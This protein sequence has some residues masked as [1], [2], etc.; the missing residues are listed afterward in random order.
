MIKQIMHFKWCTSFTVYS[1]LSTGTHHVVSNLYPLERKPLLRWYANILDNRA[2]RSVLTFL[3]I[4]GPT[5]LLTQVGNVPNQASH[6]PFDLWL[7]GWQYLS[8]R[9]W[10]CPF[11]L[12][13]NEANRERSRNTGKPNNISFLLVFPNTIRYL[14]VL[15]KVCKHNQ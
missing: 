9:H 7:T 15:T 12:V 1:V 13:E 5:S 4:K 3:L 11:V 2:H 8:R 14:S 6:L 10:D